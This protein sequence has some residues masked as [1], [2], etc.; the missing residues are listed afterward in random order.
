[1]NRGVAAPRRLNG[2]IELHLQ[3]QVGM[4]VNMD[5]VA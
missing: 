4:M 3:V 1:M 2:S 5:V